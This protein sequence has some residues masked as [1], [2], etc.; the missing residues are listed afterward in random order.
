MDGWD[1]RDHAL[2]VPITDPVPFSKTEFSIF[3]VS[4]SEEELF[5][6]WSFIQADD[7]SDFELE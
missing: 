1:P 2:W 6:H 7:E 4:D 3:Y 5:Q